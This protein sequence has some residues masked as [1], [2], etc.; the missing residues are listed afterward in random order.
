MT[1]KDIVI[2]VGTAGP[3]N[4]LTLHFDEA[5]FLTPFIFQSEIY[6]SHK[7]PIS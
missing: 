5:R 2:P 1:C 4:T 7:R 3:V 6:A